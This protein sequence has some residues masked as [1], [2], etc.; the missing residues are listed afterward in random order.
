MHL[1]HQKKQQIENMETNQKQHTKELKSLKLKMD[2]VKFANSKMTKELT[3]SEKTITNLEFE[4]KQ[5]KKKL[6]NHQ[7]T[8]EKS[9]KE[10]SPKQKKPEK[11][12]INHN[13][14]KMVPAK[15]GMLPECVIC[16]DSAM[17]HDPVCLPCGHVFGA[18]CINSWFRKKES[19]PICNTYA[20][21]ETVKTLF[22]SY[23]S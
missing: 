10:K 21:D 7:K 2:D 19:C 15:P 11:I 14:S 1:I 23:S 20:S 6:E 13:S 8:K 12:K 22:F 3:K 4:I 17:N 9:T 5:L 16:S 18:L